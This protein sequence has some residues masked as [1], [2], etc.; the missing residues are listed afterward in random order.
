VGSVSREVI[1]IPELNYECSG[2][3]GCCA[4]WPVPLTEGDYDRISSVTQTRAGFATVVS[5][6][7]QDESP[8]PPPTRVLGKRPDGRCEFLLDDN[9]CQLHVDH[10][11]E[12]KPA[13][14]KLFPYMF[15]DTPTGVY[16]TVNFGSVAAVFNSGRPLSEQADLLKS[17]F[18]LYRNLAPA[19]GRDWSGIQLVG[20]LSLTWEQYLL[21]DEQILQLITAEGP[22][23]I[24]RALNACSRFLV[25]QIPTSTRVAKPL[26]ANAR[27]KIVDQ[28]LLKRLM[29]MYLPDDHRAYNDFDLYSQAFLADIENPP[30]TR[31]IS[32]DGVT[33]GFNQLYSLT[34]G[35]LSVESE[36]LLFRYVYS[37]IF[38]KAYF[39]AGFANLS[40]L[41]GIHHL[42]VL[43]VL[44]RLKIKALCLVRRCESL[45]FTDIGAMVRTLERRLGQASFS[46]E[47]AQVLDLLMTDPERVERLI[48][49]AC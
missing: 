34:L 35:D 36:N 39:G 49:L 16:A 7:P 19:G 22:G 11:P 45:E 42:L 32:A 31:A 5:L 20:G 18:D 38:A 10:G 24:E 17:K 44:I 27:P 25:E 29:E 9:R 15:T 41:S 4:G 26:F 40:V 2:C 48:S 43:V 47:S 3:G 6:G 12:M 46:G 8:A 14:C 1:H 37:K 21:L 23:R 13:V 33:C 30:P 28:L